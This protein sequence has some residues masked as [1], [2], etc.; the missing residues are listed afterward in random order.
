MVSGRRA[1]R[2]AVEAGITVRQ[3]AEPGA[4]ITAQA[5]SS[6]C[7]GG[8]RLRITKSSSRG[9]S[10]RRVVVSW[11]QQKCPEWVAKVQREHRRHCDTPFH[12]HSP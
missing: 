1:A 9:R 12:S 6:V 10:L 5:V 7:T 11:C 8:G 3:M 4:V 2:T